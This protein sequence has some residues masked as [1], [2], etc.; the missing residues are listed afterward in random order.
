M[1]LTK[2]NETLAINAAEAASESPALLEPLPDTRLVCW[3]GEQETSEFL[4]Q[5]ALLANI[6]IGLGAETEV[7]VEPD[8]HHFNIID[9]LAD[10][11]HP[12][13]Q[14]LLA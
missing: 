4:R 13:T 5:N 1:I 6:W 12:L 11:D 9:G 2:R 10:P 8:R 3:A 14:A 7:V